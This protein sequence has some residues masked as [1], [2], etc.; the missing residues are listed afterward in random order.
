[1]P[2]P[3]TELLARYREIDGLLA[4][5]RRSPEFR[6]WQASTAELLRKA[7][8]FHPAV[9]QFQGL[10]FRAGPVGAAAPEEL[11]AI[12]AAEHDRRMHQDLGEAKRLL[13]GALAALG[14]DPDA[15]E[16]GAAPG[17][18]E[19]AVAA[20]G[21][22]APP[23]AAPAARR[24]DAALGAPRPAWSEVEPELGILLRLGLPLARAALS[25]VGARLGDLR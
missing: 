8:G 4:G 19:A 21:P 5:S 20:L 6:R 1:M 23:D 2:S 13:R 24:L 22:Q 17:A 25:A 3:A 9:V 12:P 11:A 14:V 15:P 18:L 16:P 7:L 10:R